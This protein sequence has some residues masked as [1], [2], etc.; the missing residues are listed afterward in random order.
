MKRGFCGSIGITG[1]AGPW[2]GAL[3]C[4]I[5]IRKMKGQL[6]WQTRKE[7]QPG[8]C[9]WSGYWSEQK[10]KGVEEDKFC[11]IFFRISVVSCS[12]QILHLDGC[13]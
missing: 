2:K 7:Q 4:E 1:K 3:P 8:G 9:L 12:D 10:S 13:K 6:H 5:Y 11:F